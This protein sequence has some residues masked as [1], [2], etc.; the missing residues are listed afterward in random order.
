[1]VAALVLPAVQPQH[2][3]PLSMPDQSL[4]DDTSPIKVDTKSSRAKRY[5]TFAVVALAVCICAGVGGGLGAAGARSGSPAPLLAPPPPPLAFNT[6]AAISVQGYSV[7]T[8]TQAARTAF[9]TALAIFLNVPN[10]AITITSVVSATPGGRHLLQGG[11]VVSFSVTSSSH[12]AANTIAA[13]VS[14]AATTAPTFLQTLNN[15]FTAVNLPPATGCSLTMLPTIVSTAVGAVALLGL[16]PPSPIAAQLSP[17]ISPSQPPPPRPPLPPP[18]PPPPSPPPSSPPPSPSPP[19]PP[20]P[21]P[22]NAFMCTR[23]GATCDALSDLYAATNG[24]GWAN[25]SGW[26]SAAAGITTDYCVFFGVGCDS[27]GNVT[28]MCVPCLRRVGCVS[29]VRG[30]F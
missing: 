26:A 19:Q 3:V 9:V 24:A 8:F 16:P 25:N 15:A 22:P 7:A 18:S 27:E 30:A 28:F 2:V 20:P 1:M 12:T 13:T 17:P 6:S 21:R 5:F 29:N 23:T 4:A 11:V 10:S 14:S